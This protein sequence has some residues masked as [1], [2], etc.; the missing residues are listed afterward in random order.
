MFA[1]STSALSVLTALALPAGQLHAESAAPQRPDAGTTAAAVAT[2]TDAATDFWR[3]LDDAQKAKAGFA[4]DDPERENWHFVPKARK[5]LPIG[6]L[7][8]D[9]VHLAYGLLAS[10]LSQ[11]GMRKAT[12]IMSL[13][14]VLR[15]LENGAEHRNTV[16]Y[17]ISIFGEPG[18]PKPWGW[19]F[20]GHHLSFNFTVTPGAPVSVTPTFLGANPGELKSGPR[21]GLR[22]LA[23]EEDYA[24]EL[25]RSLTPEQRKAAIIDVKAPADIITGAERRVSPLSPPGIPSSALTESQRAL[26]WRIAGEYIDRFRPDLTGRISERLRSGSQDG[27]TFAW[28][29]GTGPGEGHY[30]RIQN[31]EFVLE[32][33]NTQNGALHPH[34]VW[35]DFGNDFGTDILRR[36][37]EAEHS[38][39]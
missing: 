30:Y 17:F 10:A 19:R 7:R 20:E 36:H 13:E 11:E 24:R 29:G 2:M 23:H 31:A 27:L 18:T 25:V 35:R 4:F 5:G 12:A 3:N 1:R 37:Y 22:V 8:G 38:G 15:E 32:Y 16:N 21:A 39:N 34:T 28:T 14:K 9:Q 6:E 26:L 33:D